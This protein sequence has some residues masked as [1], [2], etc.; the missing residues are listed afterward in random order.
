[1]AKTILWVKLYI[2]PNSKKPKPLEVEIIG[3]IVSYEI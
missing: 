2:Y 3:K 1:M